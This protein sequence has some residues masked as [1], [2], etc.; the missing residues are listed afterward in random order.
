[1]FKK[2]DQR[3]EEL[4]A[5]PVLRRKRMAELSRARK[6]IFGSAVCVLVALC[7]LTIASTAL[8]ETP[9]RAMPLMV[10]GAVMIWIS[11][12]QMEFDLKI[13]RLMDR[14]QGG[15]APQ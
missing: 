10:F 1:M 9:S 11:Y 7:I 13:L 14:L 12:F 6:W 5:D 2:S 8:R 4:M 3:F 15:P